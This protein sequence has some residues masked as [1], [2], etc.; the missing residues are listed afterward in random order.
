MYSLRRIFSLERQQCEQL[1]QELDARSGELG[2][3]PSRDH[4]R[5]PFRTPDIFLRVTHPEYGTSDILAFGRNLSAGGMALLLCGYVHPGSSCEIVLQP[6]RGEPTKLT[7][8]VRHCRH[9][10]GM[11]FELGIQFD[12]T[13]EIKHYLVIHTSR[14]RVA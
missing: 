6:L 14:E 8:K 2:T 9:I 13:I 4:Q 3:P 7:G 10:Q 12:E 11:S 1:T 5:Y